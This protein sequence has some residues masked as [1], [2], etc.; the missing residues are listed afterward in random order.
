MGPRA[1]G[2]GNP[3]RAAR[4]AQRQLVREGRP[5]D[6]HELLRVLQGQPQPACQLPVPV[7]HRDRRHGDR[8]QPDCLT[9]QVGGMRRLLKLQLVVLA[10]IAGALAA[11]LP[12]QAGRNQWSMFEDHTAL[13]RAPSPGARA[14]RLAEIKRLGA[15][16]LRIQV[17]W[18]EVAPQPSAKTKPRFDSADPL[19]YAGHP[20]AYPGFFP[21]DDLVRQANAMGF[22]I[23]M[24]IT[25]DTPR[26]ASGGGK[27]T[28][29]ESANY[30]P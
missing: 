24:T 22:R 3:L 17:H 20:N 21:Y 7:R 6:R 11:P 29:F 19:A 27:S 9:D 30:K 14:N 28:S 18:N 26:W 15:D 5:G 4:A 10:L 16:T 1:A 13:V 12:A 2:Q 8:H 23:L 25:G